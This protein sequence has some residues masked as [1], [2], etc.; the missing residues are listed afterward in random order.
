MVAKKWFVAI[1]QVVKLPVKCFPHTTVCNKILHIQ[2]SGG[3]II[4][5]IQKLACPPS[6][7][8]GPFNHS[9]VFL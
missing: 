2:T 7:L 6:C 8:S 4:K 9:Q 3:A 1:L 5:K